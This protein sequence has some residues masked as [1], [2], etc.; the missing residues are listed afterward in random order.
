M[1]QTASSGW[2]PLSFRPP[3]PVLQRG[4]PGRLERL[5]HALLDE[6]QGRLLGQ[7]A[8]RKLV[9]LA[10]SGSPAGYALCNAPGGDGRGDRL[11]ELL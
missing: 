4:L 7:R 3:Q 6:S 11:D 2:A 9:G 10:E 8:D 1:V 5:R